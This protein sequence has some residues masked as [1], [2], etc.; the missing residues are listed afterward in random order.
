[1]VTREH[2]IT[3]PPRQTSPEG[4]GSG[5]TLSPPALWCY[6]KQSA[7]QM[8]PDIRKDWNTPTPNL[9][10]QGGPTQGI[11]AE[12]TTDVQSLIFTTQFKLVTISSGLNRLLFQNYSPTGCPM[13]DIDNTVQVINNKFQ[14]NRWTGGM[15]QLPSGRPR[16]AQWTT[17][18][19]R[20]LVYSI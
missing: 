19:L 18:A 11:H 5:A 3:N 8:P 6:Q 9:I 17:P 15:L 1:M 4:T 10:Y 12:E 13:T 16:M 20:A 14:N 2:I 7:R